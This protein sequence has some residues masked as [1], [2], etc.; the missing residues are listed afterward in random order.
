MKKVVLIGLHPDVVDYDKWPMLTPEK[1]MGALNA[2]KASLE[3]EGF[4]AEVLLV[5]RGE[6]AEQVVRDALGATAYDCVVIGAGVR[7][8]DAH[9]LLFER[10]VNLLH[11]LAPDA[12]IA[13]NTNPSDTAEAVK[14]WISP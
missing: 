10:L 2:E 11:D 14:R 4:S 13:F 1:L 9:F 7:K 12:K 5:D 6:T 8:D 3:E